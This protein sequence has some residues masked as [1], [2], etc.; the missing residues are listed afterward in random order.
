MKSPSL[1]DL[2]FLSQFLKKYLK[3]RKE[4]K[5]QRKIILNFFNFK[6]PCLSTTKRCE[7]LR[8]RYTMTYDFYKRGQICTK[9]NVAFL[10]QTVITELLS[11]QKN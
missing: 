6:Q 9:C 2:S 4:K 1:F 5:A 11:A 3:A 10:K 7:E 8:K